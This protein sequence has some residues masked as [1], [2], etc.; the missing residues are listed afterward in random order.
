M[1]WRA[2]PSACLSLC[3]L[4]S[5]TERLSDFR[6]ILG[7]GVLYNKLS[8]KRECREIW[9]LYSI[10]KW[11]LVCLNFP[12]S[13]PIRVKIATSCLDPTLSSNFEL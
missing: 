11:K 8:D 6:E 4:V 5:T 2:R 13:W 10:E 7:T 12:I 1:L 9:L 3:G